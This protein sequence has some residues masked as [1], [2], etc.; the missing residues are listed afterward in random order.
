MR[1]SLGERLRHLLSLLEAGD[2]EAED[3]IATLQNTPAYAGW[4]D[5]LE[6]IV[7]HIEDVEFKTAGTLVQDLLANLENK[8]VT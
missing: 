8:A 1:A 6:L 2:S 3:F 7:A 5:E 4:Q